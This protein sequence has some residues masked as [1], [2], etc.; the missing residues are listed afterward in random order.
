MRLA[1]QVL[2]NPDLVGRILEQCASEQCIGAAAQVCRLF[3]ES[4]RALPDDFW[5]K[6]AEH[7]WKQRLWL[8]ARA[9]APWKLK[10]RSLSYGGCQLCDHGAAKGGRPSRAVQVCKGCAR[11]V[12]ADCGHSDACSHR[13]R[14]CGPTDPCAI[15]TSVDASENT[16]EVASGAASAG[17]FGRR[18]GGG[19]VCVGCPES[20]SEVASGVA[21]AGERGCR[22]GDSRMCV[23]CSV[24]CQLCERRVC[25]AH[26]AG[27][28]KLCV[29]CAASL[30]R[31]PS[32][33]ELIAELERGGE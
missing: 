32:L 25:M 10:L 13:C 3:S 31:E 18:A 12:C 16:S 21:G 30:A 29:E 11:L 15:C 26:A 27:R 9:R 6:I 7:S 20:T 8:V 4:A 28:S 23:G 24:A 19:R 33:S 2:Q 17:E 14:D 5:R 1:M 22:A